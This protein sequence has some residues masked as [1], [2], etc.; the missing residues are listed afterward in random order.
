VFFCV[1]AFNLTGQEREREKERPFFKG[2]F[3]LPTTIANHSFKTLMSGV[4]DIEFSFNIPVSK[5][6][7]LGIFAQHSYLTFND[8]SIPERTN[9]TMQIVG[10]G[11]T[12]GYTV[13][14]SD[15]FSLEFAVNGGYSYV[16]TSSETCL[17][18]TGNRVYKKGGMSIKPDLS[19]F[20]RSSEY[21]SFGILF[22]YQFILSEFGPSNLCLS[23][24]EGSFPTDYVGPSH[25]FAIGFGFKANIPPRR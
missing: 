9:A 24:F 7:H 4:S 8:L 14:T 15:K 20:I 12:L 18:S 3:Q 25:L 2:S 11:V 21:L 23:E 5:S 13:P 22:S 17:Q 10:T 19:L 16:L 6:M 1:I